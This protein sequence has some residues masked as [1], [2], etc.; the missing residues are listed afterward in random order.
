M[1]AM[2]I[3]I[4]ISRFETECSRR[5]EYQVIEED[6]PE[7]RTEKVESCREATETNLVGPRC[8]QVSVR[9]CQIVQRSVRKARPRHQ[10]RRVPRKEC[11]RLPCRE[12][13][14]DQCRVT[15]RL[16]LSQR[17]EE[18]CHLR[19]SRVCQQGECRRTLRRDCHCQDISTSTSTP[20]ESTTPSTSLTSP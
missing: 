13:R 18:T 8:R 14:R 2:N 7:C 19:P 16:K 20:S 5:L 4:M 15:I 9:R 3:I 6:Y 17:P 10:C 1:K 12:E 11:A